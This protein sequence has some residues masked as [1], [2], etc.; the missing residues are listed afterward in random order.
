MRGEN[1]SKQ[2]DEIQVT[3]KLD[4]PIF[5]TPTKKAVELYVKTE[6]ISILLNIENNQDC[7]HKTRT[8]TMS[9][10]FTTIFF[11]IW[12]NFI[13]LGICFSKTHLR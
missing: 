9:V 1:D 6:F 7:V 13:F 11:F 2:S 4:Y 10:N 12:L 3:E 8:H 5:K